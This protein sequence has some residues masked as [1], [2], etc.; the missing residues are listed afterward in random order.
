M[1]SSQ[2]KIN[3]A[4]RATQIPTQIRTKINQRVMTIITD[5]FQQLAP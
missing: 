2:L 4:F 1:R 3:F 5:P